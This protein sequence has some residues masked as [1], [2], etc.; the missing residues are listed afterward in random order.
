MALERMLISQLKAQALQPQLNELKIEESTA[1]NYYLNNR[2]RFILPAKYRFAMLMQEHP[3]DITN[4][5]KQEQA[6]KILTHLDSNTE[7]KA[8]M[9]FGAQAI[10]FSDHLA[11]RYRGGD[12]GWFEQSGSYNLPPEV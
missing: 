10:R 2:Q 1:R 8:I 12:I 6:N 3:T 4:K 7:V 5:E 11:S 9:D